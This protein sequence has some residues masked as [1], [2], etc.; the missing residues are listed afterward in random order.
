MIIAT[1][2]QT[3]MQNRPPWTQMLTGTR[4]SKTSKD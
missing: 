4:P 2:T 3:Q 1:Q